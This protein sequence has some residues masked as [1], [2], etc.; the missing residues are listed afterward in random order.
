MS[1]ESRMLRRENYKLEK[2][3]S[4]ETEDIQTDIVVLH[5][6]CKYKRDRSAKGAARYNADAVL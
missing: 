3:L 6:K 4:K 2:Q 1:R 5:K